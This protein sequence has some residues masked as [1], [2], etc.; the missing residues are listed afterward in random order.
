MNN[1]RKMKRKKKPITKKQLGGVT[2]DVVQTPV[3]QNK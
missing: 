1:K 2:Q 3:L